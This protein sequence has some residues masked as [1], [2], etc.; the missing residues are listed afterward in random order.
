[1]ADV[2]REVLENTI[3]DV[4]SEFIDFLKKIEKAKKKNKK[5]EK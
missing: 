5:N 4:V 3:D 2:S 1:M